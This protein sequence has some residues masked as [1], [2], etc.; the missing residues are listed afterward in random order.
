MIELEEMSRLLN[1]RV[2]LKVN[3]SVS[4][5]EP[6]SKH[7]RG[8]EDSGYKELN[9]TRGYKELNPH[10]SDKG[11]KSKI[12][13]RACLS[14]PARDHDF[15][16]YSWKKER[17]LFTYGFRVKLTIVCLVVVLKRQF[18][19]K[20][21]ISIC[22]VWVNPDLFNLLRAF[23]YLFIYF[24]RTLAANLVLSF[25]EV[26]FLHCACWRKSECWWKNACINRAIL[27]GLILDISAWAD[28]FTSWISSILCLLRKV[29]L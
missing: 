10:T 21:C 18:S 14:E 29:F 23:I 8:Y 12:F 15:K 1:I 28:V 24:I 9:H 26:Q 5:I 13:K 22:P 16:F 6:R 3:F 20:I 2:S 19:T 27:T 4:K 11:T 17:I 25:S 7:T